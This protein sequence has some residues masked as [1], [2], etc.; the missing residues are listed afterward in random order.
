MML[1]DANQMKYQHMCFL[2]KTLHEKQKHEKSKQFQIG[3]DNRIKQNSMKIEKI[4]LSIGFFVMN[5]TCR[6]RSNDIIHIFNVFN[7]LSNIVIANL[8]N[9]NRHLFIQF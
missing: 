7:T 2:F 8:K 4:V 6:W 3:F 9:G 5:V 1:N